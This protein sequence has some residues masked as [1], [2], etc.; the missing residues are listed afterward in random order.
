MGTHSKQ[1]CEPLTVK[2]AHFRLRDR[3]RGW[4]GIRQQVLREPLGDFFLNF[5]IFALEEDLSGGQIRQL[6]RRPIRPVGEFSGSP[7]V[8][9]PR[10]HCRG[11]YSI[12]GWETK[13]PHVISAAK[14]KQNKTNKQKKPAGTQR[15]YIESW[16]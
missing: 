16:K 9:T 4:W 6:G 10:F 2:T 14:K 8:K 11:P 7:V 5:L 13:I 3:V 1:N 15:K 12:P